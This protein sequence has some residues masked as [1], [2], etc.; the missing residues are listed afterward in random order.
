M[1][2]KTDSKGVLLPH[3][4]RVTKIGGFIRKL[5]LDELPQLVNVLKGD[6]PR[7]VLVVICLYITII[8]IKGIM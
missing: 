5:S 4:L 7:P 6:G 8:K 3:H 2:D 1:T